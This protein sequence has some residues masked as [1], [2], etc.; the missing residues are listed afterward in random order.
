MATLTPFSPKNHSW[1]RAADFS[2]LFATLLPLL[3]FAYFL[4]GSAGCARDTRPEAPDSVTG[5]TSGLG[6]DA[7]AESVAADESAADGPAEF[8]RGLWVLA[9]GSERVL[10]DATRVSPLLDRAERLGATDLFVQVYRGG[11]AFYPAGP[12]IER[13][14]EAEADV[15]ADLI[16]RAQAKGL[17]VHAWVNVLSLS[18]RKDA[19]MIRDLGRDAIL[20]DRQGRSILDYPDFELPQPDRRYYRMGTRGI[21]LDPAHP[22][23][24]ERI[25]MTYLDLITRY[26][27][28]D[29]LHL[30]YIRH[31]GVLPFSPG[32]RFGVGL[33]F[34]YGAPS[35]A[36]YRAETGRPDPIEGAKPGVVRGASAWDDWRRHQVTTLVEEIASVTRTARPGLVVSAAVIAYMDRAYLSLAQDWKGWLEAGSIDLAIPMVYT[37][38]DRLLR[39]QLENYAGW[40][41][42][43]R[44]WPGVGVWLF[45]DTP[46]RAVGQLEIL[47]RNGFSGEVL[48]SDDA[49]AK[50]SILE[51][52]LA[53]L[54]PS[55][56]RA[57][58]SQGQALGYEAR[59]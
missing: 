8:A 51:A 2:R 17:R 42:A 30:D 49:I 54:P 35:R 24:R 52:A 26:P 25:V 36:R 33:E 47:R 58:R 43:K 3:L 16:A 31:P 18:T 10:A 59:E 21:Y 7:T 40:P 4:L 13:A 12:G 27:E 11:R 45:D 15:L 1:P 41:D 50:A 5:L 20:V 32:S 9:E 34:G 29:G 28:L 38:D 22:A 46:Q 37:L 6:A 44:I 56:A 19:A 14:V 53:E 55:A 39:Y 23:V 48:F 57:E